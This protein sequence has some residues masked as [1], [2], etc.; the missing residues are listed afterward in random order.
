MRCHTRYRS[1]SPSPCR[2]ELQ[3]VASWKALQGST[4]SRLYA[5]SSI[6]RGS[7][8]RARRVGRS[9]GAGQNIG[10]ICDRALSK[11]S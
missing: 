11:L 7:P 9:L 6:V 2:E 8:E 1:H 3:C 10:A 5:R 4:R